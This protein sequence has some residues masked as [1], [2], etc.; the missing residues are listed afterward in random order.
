MIIAWTGM[1]WCKH[2]F[3]QRKLVEVASLRQ[4][5][6][7]LIHY[8]PT[9]ISGWIFNFWAVTLS[10]ILP[11]LS[12]KNKLESQNHDKTPWLD[13]ECACPS[14]APINTYLNQSQNCFCLKSFIF[15]QPKHRFHVLF[16]HSWILN[17]IDCF[18]L[19]RL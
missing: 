11:K 2:S 15:T 4:K 5:P 3:W 18:S 1:N 7:Q 17:L 13:Y 9:N 19:F 6:T 14:T 8:R 12:L 16:P 10:T